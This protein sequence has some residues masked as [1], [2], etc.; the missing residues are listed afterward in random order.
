MVQTILKTKNS[1]ASRFLLQVSPWLM[2]VSVLETKAVSSKKFLKENTHIIQPLLHT[3]YTQ[4]KLVKNL[5]NPRSLYFPEDKLSQHL[6]FWRF[7]NFSDLRIYWKLK[8]GEKSL[9]FS[10][11][12]R[13]KTIHSLKF[14]DTKIFSFLIGVGLGVNVSKM[15]NCDWNFSA[16]FK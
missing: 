10:L 14:S 7:L 11:I 1:E 8:G 9:K 3:R 4:V 15:A 12:Y 16:S 13:K 2:E 6:M 5:S